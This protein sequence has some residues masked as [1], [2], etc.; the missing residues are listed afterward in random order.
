VSA[1]GD[2][3]ARTVIAVGL[4]SIPMATALMCTVRA[5]EWTLEQLPSGATLHKVTAEPAEYKGRKALKVELTEAAT[6][7][8]PGID[9]RDMPTFVLIPATFKNGTIEV[10][11]LGRLNEKGPPDARAFVGLAYHVTGRGE[12]FESVYLRPLNGRK[13]NPPPPRDERAIQYY[14]YP[15]WKFDRL[16]KEH[17]DG[18]FESGA[19]IN[20]DEWNSLKI[21]VENGRLSVRINGR[22]E[23]ALA[24]AKVA[25]AAGSIGLWVDIGTVGY[26]ANLRVTTR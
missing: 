18:R 8:K 21:A 26:F 9:F 2:M 14:A 20:A 15:D 16:R 23:L 7:G 6:R 19:D 13:A 11:V 5:Q 25:P 10:D 1:V 3:R 17:P 12:R 24:D 22:E 4:A